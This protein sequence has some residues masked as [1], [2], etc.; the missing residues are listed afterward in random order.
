MWIR[1]IETIA[2]YHW[3]VSDRRDTTSIRSDVNGDFSS[4]VCKIHA[5]VW[6][7][8]SAH[9]VTAADALWR[10]VATGKHAPVSSECNVVRSDNALRHVGPSDPFWRSRSNRSLAAVFDVGLNRVY[11]LYDC[12]CSISKIGHAKRVRGDRQ[13]W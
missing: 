3:N 4:D 5:A 2:K 6:D 1:M 12:G 8:G 7:V 9:S 13:V 10:F 11:I